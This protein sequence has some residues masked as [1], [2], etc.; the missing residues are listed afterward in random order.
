MRKARVILRSFL[1]FES[2]IIGEDLLKSF[3]SKIIGE[4]L[5]GLC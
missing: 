5:V 4:D 2:K 3:K 1:S